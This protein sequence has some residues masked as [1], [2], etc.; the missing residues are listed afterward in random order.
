MLFDRVAALFE[1]EGFAL[2]TSISPFMLKSIDPDP[3]RDGTLTHLLR[4]DRDWRAP[5]GAPGMGEI[6]L[7]EAL[8]RAMAPSRIFVH[9]IGA[10]WTPVALALAFPGARV[11]AIGGVPA[12]MTLLGELAAKHRLALSVGKPE[13]IAELIFLDPVPTEIAQ[14]AAFEAV[15]PHCGPDTL[16]VVHGVAV[17]GLR[18]GFDAIAAS[19]P[20]HRAVIL[21]RTGS[22]AGAL[23]PANAPPALARALGGLV[24]PLF[25]V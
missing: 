8:A 16:V 1:A 20:A 5:A 13:G 6:Y 18:A 22:G 4:A 25:K 15:R 14:A 19:L 10:A 23:I 24:D 21:T 11:S 12:A 17:R 3:E 2:R 9:G 7:F